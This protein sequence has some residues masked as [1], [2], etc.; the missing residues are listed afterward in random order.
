MVN[1]YTLEPGATIRIV[2]TFRDCSARNKFVEGT[3][4]H[5][6]GRIYLPYHAGHTVYFREVTMYLCDDDETC[7]IVQ[8]H[9]AEYFELIEQSDYQQA[10]P[11]SVFQ[12]ANDNRVLRSAGRAS[13]TR[14]GQRYKTVFTGMLAVAIAFG[15]AI[16]LG[17]WLRARYPA[18][19]DRAFG[20]IVAIILFGIAAGVMRFLRPL[21]LPKKT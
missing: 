2:K 13:D 11:D 16:P 18:I 9:N 14:R 15:V 8:N 20:Q 7:A 17:F 5:F 21:W 1:I 19:P 6:T 12:S 4:L 3:I 10:G